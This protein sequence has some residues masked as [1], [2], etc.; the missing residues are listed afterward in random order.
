MY[1]DITDLTVQTDGP[2]RRILSSESSKQELEQVWRKHRERRKLCICSITLERG[3]TDLESVQSERKSSLKNK[4]LT[5]NHITA[6]IS[7]RTEGENGKRGTNWRQSDRTLP[8]SLCRWDFT[9]GSCCI[10]PQGWD[11]TRE[12]R[13]R[14]KEDVPLVSVILHRLHWSAGV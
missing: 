8:F 13:G 4:T 6:Y 2:K 3:E 5:E 9:S 1:W 11:E 10:S 12:K 14:G 7:H